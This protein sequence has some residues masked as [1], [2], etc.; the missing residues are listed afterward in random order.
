MLPYTRAKASLPFLSFHDSYDVCHTVMV[1]M[2]NVQCRPLVLQA[3][4]RI[5]DTAADRNFTLHI[6]KIH[7]NMYLPAS[8]IVLAIPIIYFFPWQMEQK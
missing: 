7:K 2:Q 6:G 8:R 1:N 5:S 4:G 3:H